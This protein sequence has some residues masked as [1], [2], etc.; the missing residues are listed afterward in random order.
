MSVEDPKEQ[1]CWFKPVDIAFA[2]DGSGSIGQENFTLSLQFIKEFLEP[3][4]I[5]NSSIRVAA[6]KFS[7]R[8]HAESAILFG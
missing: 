7:N 8:A 6:V 3:F 4:T 2:I 1:S 5:S